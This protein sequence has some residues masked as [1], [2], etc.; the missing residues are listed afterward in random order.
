MNT[1]TSSRVRVRHEQERA[2]LVLLGEPLDALRSPDRPEREREHAD[3]EQEFRPRATTTSAFSPPLNLSTG[4]PQLRV[5]DLV[6]VAQGPAVEAG[7]GALTAQVL[8][9][10]SMARQQVA[11]SGSRHIMHSW[12]ASMSRAASSSLQ[13][14]EH[15]M[16]HLVHCTATKRKRKT[17]KRDM[18]VHAGFQTFHHAIQLGFS[19]NSDA[20]MFI[21]L[22][23]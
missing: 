11:G 8:A 10:R 17:R 14:S 7:D 4:T 23:T 21:N 6:M 12:S 22:S 16:W 19:R 1:G 13:H 3:E 9:R 18:S 20:N 2:R 15:E 5:A